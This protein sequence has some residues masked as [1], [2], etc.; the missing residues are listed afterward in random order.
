MTDRPTTATG[1]DHDPHPA[2]SPVTARPVAARQL[3]DLGVDG[4]QLTVVGI[5]QLPRDHAGRPHPPTTPEGQPYPLLMAT[6]T[7]L[8]PGR[9]VAG[10]THAALLD[11]LI[12]GYADADPVGRR[13]A[14]FDHARRVHRELVVHLALDFAD[15]LSPAERDLL[16]TDPTALPRTPTVWTAAAPFVLVDLAVRPHTDTPAVVVPTELAGRPGPG[17]ILLRAA[18]EATY[19]PSLATAGL[20]DLAEPQ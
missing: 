9:L 10:T 5:N 15:H 20:L 12:P 1:P 19:L 7:L 13:R 4:W 11:A 3:R 2:T 16:L 8:P 14:R 6:G 17:V 18:D